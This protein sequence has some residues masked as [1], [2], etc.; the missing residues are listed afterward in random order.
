VS[1][2]HTI[3]GSGTARQGCATLLGAA[4]AAAATLVVCGLLVFVGT[5]VDDFFSSRDDLADRP[6]VPV[7]SPEGA[8]LPEPRD[9]YVFSGVD[10]IAAALGVRVVRSAGVDRP[11]AARCDV[12]RLAASFSCEVDYDGEVV[13]YAVSVEL[14]PAGG[15]SAWEAVPDSLIVTREGVLAAVWRKFSQHTTDLRCEEGIPERAR[16][17]PGTTLA[18]RCYFKPTEDHPALGDQRHLKT[19]EVQILIQDGEI[20]AAA[21]RAE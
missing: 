11:V 6:G 12:E 9:G 10:G 1:T 5:K 7:P 3:A 13:T 17:A 21:R 16:V 8:E 19:V 20:V 2:D 14:D 18:Q 15:W 4:A